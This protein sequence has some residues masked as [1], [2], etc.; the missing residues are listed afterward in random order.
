MANFYLMTTFVILLTGDEAAHKATW[1]TKYLPDQG[2]TTSREGRL[3]SQRSRGL[4]HDVRVVDIREVQSH[5]IVEP[6]TSTEQVVGAPL[7]GGWSRLQDPE[8]GTIQSFS[9]L[10]SFLY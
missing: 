6:A 10:I 8:A 5:H 3:D 7:R 9:L 1:V 4:G 2:A